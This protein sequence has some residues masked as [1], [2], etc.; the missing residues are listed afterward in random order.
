MFAR[1]VMAGMV[2]LAAFAVGWRY[3][4]GSPLLESFPVFTTALPLNC[5]SGTGSSI[6]CRVKVT[7][8]TAN[9][10]PVAATDIDIDPPKLPL[11]GTTKTIIVWNFAGPNE[12]YFCP[13]RGHGV[14]F[15]K[16]SVEYDGQFD[17]NYATD[18]RDGG[19]ASGTKV[20]Y[21]YYRWR[22]ENETRTHGKEYPYSIEFGNK[23]GTVNCK[24][25]PWIRNG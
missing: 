6:E 5:K 11:N 18:D 1:G 23:E 12:Y 4:T 13:T 22:D 19:G 14:W 17:R 16:P 24:W 25:D 21:Q 20:C 9:A 10:C 2:L 8:K 3:F 15:D 7:V